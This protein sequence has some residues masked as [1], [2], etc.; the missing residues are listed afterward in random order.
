MGRLVPRRPDLLHFHLKLTLKRT[1]RT[2]RVP[3]EHKRLP[4]HAPNLRKDAA[5]YAQ[6]YYE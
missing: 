3:S 1:R 2:K 6:Y 5:S 4:L